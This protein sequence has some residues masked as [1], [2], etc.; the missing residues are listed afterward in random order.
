MAIR[1]IGTNNVKKPKQFLVGD[2]SRTLLLIP[3]EEGG[4][5]VRSPFD[6][7]LITEAETVE[8]AFANAADAEAM[9]AESR[10]KLSRLLQ[11]QAT[12]AR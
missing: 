5:T 7:A 12:S 4:F 10:K 8:E 3:A 9:L 6:T 2:G 1:N 11:A